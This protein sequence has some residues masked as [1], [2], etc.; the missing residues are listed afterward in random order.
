MRAETSR[1]GKDGCRK[2]RK[3]RKKLQKL[4]QNQNSNISELSQAGE[5]SKK[6]AEMLRHKEEYNYESGNY[7]KQEEIAC[8]LGTES[9]NL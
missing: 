4:Q 6:I 7:G 8:K 9:K 1:H 3:R 5:R 2:F